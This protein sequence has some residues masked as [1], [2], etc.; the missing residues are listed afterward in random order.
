[1]KIHSNLKIFFI[2]TVH[3]EW[4]FNISNT[5]ENIVCPSLSCE[6]VRG[7]PSIHIPGKVPYQKRQAFSSVT[8]A[9]RLLVV[10]ICIT[11]LF[12]SA[13]SFWIRIKCLVS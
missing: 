13:S 5:T 6:S 12:S 9:L 11:R 8:G 7:L 4:D 10:D 1:M 3:F 2:G